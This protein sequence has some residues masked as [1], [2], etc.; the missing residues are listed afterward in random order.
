MVP[1]T[2]TDIQKEKNNFIFYKN[3]QI[4]RDTEFL[5]EHNIVDY[6][7]LVGIQRDFSSNHH[8]FESSQTNS[9]LDISQQNTEKRAETRK[10]DTNERKVIWSSL[11]RLVDDSNSNEKESEET[12][13]VREK[14]RID[15]RLSNMSA[16]VELLGEGSPMSS[17]SKA[18]LN[19]SSKSVT[20][21]KKFLTPKRDKAKLLGSVTSSASST[22]TDSFQVHPPPTA[23]SIDSTD[24][25]NVQKY[26]PGPSPKNP[27]RRMLSSLW[28]PGSRIHPVNIDMDHNTVVTERMVEDLDSIREVAENVFS[29]DN[30]QQCLDSLDTRDSNRRNLPDEVNALHILDGIDTRQVSCSKTLKR[31][32]PFVDITLG[33]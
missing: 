31:Q 32:F 30:W 16:L 2:G 19:N 21:L 27:V 11:V 14:M 3:N 12:V 13:S 5:K 7:L 24:S 15:S 22:P 25:I 9:N 18:S 1:Q 26:A 23:Q 29:L 6:S 17:P 33:S 4:E 28:R 8:P 10:L 20:I